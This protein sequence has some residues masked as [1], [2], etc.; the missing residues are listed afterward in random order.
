M[1]LFDVINNLK[2]ASVG[3]LT[4]GAFF[5]F[6]LQL[7]DLSCVVYVEVFKESLGSLFVLVTDLFG[8]GVNLLLPL[9]FTTTE[10]DNHVNCGFYNE[11]KRLIHLNIL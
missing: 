8:L 3:K 6:D 7:R 1:I 9:L 10:S 4:S 11:Q 5:T 2:E